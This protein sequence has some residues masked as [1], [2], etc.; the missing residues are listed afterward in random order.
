MFLQTFQI[1]R[2]RIIALYAGN[3]ANIN[4]LSTSDSNHKNLDLQIVMGD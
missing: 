1:Y 3:Y 2:E 4:I